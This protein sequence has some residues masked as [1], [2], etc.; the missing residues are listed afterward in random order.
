M[1][2]SVHDGDRDQSL[3]VK[4]ITPTPFRSWLLNPLSSRP[5]G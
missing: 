1:G 3:K 5:G 4:G 2:R